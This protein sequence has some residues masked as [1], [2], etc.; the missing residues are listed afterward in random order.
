MMKIL[1]GR[2]GKNLEK[3]FIEYIVKRPWK[4]GVN[5]AMIISNFFLL[6]HLAWTLRSFHHQF[7]VYLRW[8]KE[9]PTFKLIKEGKKVGGVFLR[10]KVNT[11]GKKRITLTIQCSTEAPWLWIQ[12]E[13]ER[14]KETSI[15]HLCV[16]FIIGKRECCFFIIEKEK[17]QSQETSLL[18]VS[19]GKE[20]KRSVFPQVFS[21][22][23]WF[24]SWLKKAPFF[25]LALLL[26][27][28]MSWVVYEN[29]FFFKIII[30]FK[31]N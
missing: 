2:K 10:H 27:M 12:R 17:R 29:L 15:I 28:E 26:H 31:K 6:H 4:N 25:F 8:W 22:I 23:F 7:L 14:K 30:T 21:Y 16:A 19:L 5:E 9:L 11:E 3:I 13:K 20:N 24:L 18:F 1:E